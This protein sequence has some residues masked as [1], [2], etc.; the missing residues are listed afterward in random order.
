MLYASIN[1]IGMETSLL[2]FFTNNTKTLTLSFGGIDFEMDFLFTMVSV[3]ETKGII[4]SLSDSF[5][6]NYFDEDLHGFID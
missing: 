5:Q 1:S 3:W 2:I 6:L 4:P